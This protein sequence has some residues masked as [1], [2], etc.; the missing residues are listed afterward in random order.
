MDTLTNGSTIQRPTETW[1]L[2][3]RRA[4]EDKKNKVTESEKAFRQRYKLKQGSAQHAWY[5]ACACIKWGLDLE[6]CNSLLI[7]EWEMLCDAQYCDALKV[8]DFA[9]GNI[10]EIRDSS[11]RALRQRNKETLK[12]ILTKV[13]SNRTLSKAETIDKELEQAFTGDTLEWARDCAAFWILGGLLHD[14]D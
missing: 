10:D 2:I 3:A 5:C 11:E 8:F 9:Y 14:Q 13:A 1:R 6:R 7:E 12:A 4:I